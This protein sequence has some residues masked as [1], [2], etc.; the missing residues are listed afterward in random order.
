MHEEKETIRTHRVGTITLGVSLIF[1]GILFMIK[2][3]TN[4][5]SYEFVL[6]FWPVIFIFLGFEILFSFLTDKKDRF[7]YDKGG[8]FLII[9]LSIF[10]I[11]MA[12][13]EFMVNYFYQIMNSH[14][15]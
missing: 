6:K 14:I 7:I 13:A 1:F 8:I 10:S 15:I 5:L 2:T 3:F 11:C 4:L 12:G 9:L